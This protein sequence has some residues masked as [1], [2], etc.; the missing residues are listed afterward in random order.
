MNPMNPIKPFAESSEQ[1][2]QV[3]LAIIQ[4][5]FSKLKRVLEIASGTGQHA[6]YFSQVMPDL[7]WQP[8]DLE[9]ALPGIQS[10]VNESGLE[11]LNQPL[12]LDVSSIN[13]PQQ[14]FDAIFSANSLHIMSQQHVKDFFSNVD[15]VLDKNGL[16]TIYGPFNY[17]GQFTSESNQHFDAWL[18]SRNPDSGIKEF[19]WCNQLAESA[20][21][22]LIADHEMP[23]NNRIL[24]WQKTA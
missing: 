7:N 19:E 22:K 15:R 21:F 1:N 13:W 11:N 2:K 14:T 10:W 9:N 6:V 16:I 8:S 12:A 23:Q 3:I 18:K 5:L 17:Q 20:G 4:P 24:I